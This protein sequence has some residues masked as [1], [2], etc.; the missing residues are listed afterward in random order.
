MDHIR[1][2]KSLKLTDATRAIYSAAQLSFLPQRLQRLLS[3]RLNRQENHGQER[4]Q[5][6]GTG[7][8]NRGDGVCASVNTDDRGH[9]PGNTIQ[10]TGDTGSGAAVRG[11]EDLGGISVQNTVHHHLEKGFQRGAEKL[12]VRVLRGRE[13]KQQDTR[14]QGRGG[15]GTLTA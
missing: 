12:N 4:G 15:H 1:R 10:T 14:D 5:N 11:G 3:L 8:I 7:G 13:A 9:E 6:Q 2:A